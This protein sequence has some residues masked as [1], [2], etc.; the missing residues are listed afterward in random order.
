M[1]PREWGVVT[2]LRVRWEISIAEIKKNYV[3]IVM[4]VMQIST[5]GI[6]YRTTH[7][8]TQ[9]SSDENGWTSYAVGVP[10]ILI[11]SCSSTLSTDWLIIHILGI[12]DLTM[13][14]TANDAVRFYPQ[15]IDNKHYSADTNLRVGPHKF[16]ITTEIAVCP[17]IC[18]LL[19]QHTKIWSW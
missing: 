6:L 10:C 16:F 13:E 8:H 17:S 2:V 7:T 1:S 15:T 14:V 19:Q 9:M 18:G 11:A 3:L 5:Q 12:E 4:I